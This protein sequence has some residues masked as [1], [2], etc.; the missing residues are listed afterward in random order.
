MEKLIVKDYQSKNDVTWKQWQEFATAG[1]GDGVDEQFLTNRM[2]KIFYKIS[3]SDARK[4]QAD[5]ID[6]LISKVLTVLNQPTSKFTPLIMVDDV[7]YGFFNFAKMSYGELVD[8]D[9]F[10]EQ[11]DWINISS[12]VY[13]PVIS[14]NN[15]GE[16]RIKP[17]VGPND[18]L[19]DI[20]MS[21]VEGYQSL[22]MRSLNRLN[23][24]TLTSTTTTE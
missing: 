10:R 21:F 18:D 24:L 6:L 11:N 16:Y 20:P 22:F 7:E 2:L 5:Q 12:I 23:N 17:Y 1:G 14:K 4:L 13:R 3:L 9:F 19:K 15:K 8:L